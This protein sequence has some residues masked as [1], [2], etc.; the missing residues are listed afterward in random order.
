MEIRKL[1]YK[2]LKQFTNKKFDDNSNIYSIGI[3]SLDLIELVTKAEEILEV[4]IPDEELKNIKTVKNIIEVFK[5]A[6]NK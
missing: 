4:H 5:K 3:D 2:N 6:I 1:I